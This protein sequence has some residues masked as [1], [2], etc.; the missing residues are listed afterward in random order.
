M[1]RFTKLIGVELLWF[2]CASAAGAMIW[3]V[4]AS[5]YN[6]ASDA[7]WTAN[8]HPPPLGM[9]RAPWEWRFAISLTPYL[10]SVVV[11]IFQARTKRLWPSPAQ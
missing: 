3:I 11:R 6:N 7:Y 8:G 4:I 9:Y 2:V 1:L 5:G 10:L